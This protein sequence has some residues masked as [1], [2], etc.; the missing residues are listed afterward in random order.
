MKRSNLRLRFCA[1]LWLTATALSSMVV[2]EEADE[3]EWT[4]TVRPGDEIWNIASRY[5]GS[6]S[7]A[8]RIIEFNRLEDERLLRPGTRLRIPVKWLVRQPAT[9]EVLN[10]RGTARLLTP[11]P[12]PATPGRQI[13]MGHRLVTADGAVL[14][15]FADGS[16]LRVAADSEV[17]FNILTAYG[18][19]GMVDTHL[20]FY[21]GRG[22]SNVIRRN[23]ASSFRISSPAGTAAVR[24]TEFR[25]AVQDDGSLT[26]TLEGDVGFLRDTETPVPAGYGLAASPAGDVREALLSAPVWVSSPGSYAFGTE[27]RW[28]PL[29]G[30]GQYRISI[31][32]ASDPQ[33]PVH[34]EVRET[35]ALRLPDLPPASYR[36]AVRGISKSAL[37]GYESSLD[38]A[39][40][41]PAPVSLSQAVYDSGDV[42]LQWQTDE[43]GPYQVQVSLDP[44]FGQI[45]WEQ[46]LSTSEVAP[47]LPPGQYVWRVKSD[48][49]DYSPGQPLTVRPRP[50]TDVALGS[51]SLR[52]TADWTHGSADGYRV[53]ISRDPDF[54]TTLIDTV[55][56]TPTYAIQLDR[57]GMYRVEITAIENDID[58]TPVVAETGVYRR[59]WWLLGVLVVPFLL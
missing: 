16:S 15:G 51:Q 46:N 30:A 31:F 34:V 36:V 18:D 47:V 25:V 58:S 41:R 28:Q 35:A 20:R 50:V 3:A 53:R 45:Q 1:L 13:E 5:C 27:L 21:R 48:R 17:L 32:D 11:D 2:A 59:P 26:E 38:V 33:T 8:E 44:A 10:V 57:A 4:Y 6:A 23:D 54:A 43:S 14:V 12:E 24:G 19:T 29:A 55:V 49:S 42:Q 39:L 40:T 56:T 52:L 37:E 9:A 7:F 22:T